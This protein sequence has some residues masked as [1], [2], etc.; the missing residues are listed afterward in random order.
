MSRL[1]LYSTVTTDELLDDDYPSEF[2]WATPA[3]EIILRFKSNSLFAIPINMPVRDVEK[4][5]QHSRISIHPVV[6]IDNALVG[7]LNKSELNNQEIIIRQAQGVELEDLSVRDFY[8]PK[9]KVMTFDIQELEKSTVSDVV[10]ALKQVRESCAF[11]RD[12]E[13]HK[14]LGTISL[15]DI[16]KT[17]GS[18]ILDSGANTFLEAFSI[19]HKHDNSS[20]KRASNIL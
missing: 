2:S 1:N 15:E 17:L 3:T 20:L 7:I 11:V 8:L 16:A 14:I 5:L 6:D 13:T 18:D 10:Q 9:S 12:R 4:L 19:I